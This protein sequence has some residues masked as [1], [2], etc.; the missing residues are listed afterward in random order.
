MIYKTF[1]QWKSGNVLEHG[2]PRTEYY[3]EDQLDLVEMGWNYGYD[4]GRAVEQALDKKAENARELGLDY[5]PAQKPVTPSDENITDAWVSASDSDGVA[6]DGPSFERGY[7]LGRGEYDEYTGALV[8][9]ALAEQPAQQEPVAWKLVPREPTH[10]MLKAMDEC[11]TEGYDERLYAGHAASVYMAAVDA[12]PTPPAQPQQEPVVWMYVNKSTHETKFQKHMRDFVD[13]SLWSEVPL[14]GEPL[15]NHE[16]QCVCG[17]V[18]CGD[19]MVHLPDKR[20]PAQ[21]KPLTDEEI[22]LIVADC[23]SSHQHTDIHFARAI[24]AKLKEKN[25]G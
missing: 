1:E 23:A 3:S 16:F 19:E 5:E 22:I 13:H 8:A 18:W 17:A 6:Y 10:E 9:A 4:A 21:R 15:A 20:P 12:A 25:N 24:E 11:S 2:V 7:R 14:Y